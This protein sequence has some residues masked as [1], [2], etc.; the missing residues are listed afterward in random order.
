MNLEEKDRIG[1][2]LRP[3]LEE[4]VFD[5]LSEAY[6]ERSGLADILTGVPVPLK[7]N[8]LG[9]IS[10]LTI[11]KCMAFVIGCDPEFKYKE[12]YLAYIKRMFEVRFANAL[13]AEGV[14]TAATKK[15]Y[16]Y[17]C[18]L[19]RAAMQIEP[20]NA[21]A[22][23]CYGRAC[24]DAYG[25]AAENLESSEEAE[26]L[27][28]RFKA[29]ALEAF[30]VA[31][32]KDP[33]LADAYYFLGYA[34]LNMGL[35]IKA[36]LTWEEYMRLTEA[37]PKAAEKTVPEAAPQTS[38][39]ASAENAPKAAEMAADS[40][41]ANS[42]TEIFA[43][44]DE[45]LENSS[46]NSPAN[47]PS[48]ENSEYAENLREVREEIAERLAALEKPVE[49]E[50]GYNLVISGRYEE[51]IRALSPYKEGE[52]ASWW[53]LWF[54]MGTAYGELGETDE[55]IACF[56]EV[57][58]YA[59]SNIESMEE[60]VKLYE[61]TGNAEK[62]EKYTKKIGIVKDNMEKDRILWKEEKQPGTKLN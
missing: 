15:S 19:F 53:P 22:Y 46:K 18:I 13:I 26:E 4:V 12:N 59:P 38:T 20:D 21:G 62:A 25:L 48:A 33:K 9:K 44:K 47:N 11:A 41:S 29:E 52:F 6:L 24:R 40:P 34:Y 2:Y 16:D 30:E 32:L 17:A 28:G 14:E 60:L 8:E 55:A 43:E 49:I 7:K 42:D 51:G 23:Y 27:V 57:L 61:K 35:Y 1:Q 50:K 56:T 54:Y 3:R 10:T 36:K 37:A 31:T 45:T 58:K 5:E 39:K